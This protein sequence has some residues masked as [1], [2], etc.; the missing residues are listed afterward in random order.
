MTIKRELSDEN[1][2]TEVLKSVFGHDSNNKLGTHFFNELMYYLNDFDDKMIEAW[3]KE[4]QGR[5]DYLRDE[6]DEHIDFKKLD[7]LQIVAHKFGY[8]GE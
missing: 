3:R 2:I 5:H 7:K 8:R 1:L 4:M 6:N